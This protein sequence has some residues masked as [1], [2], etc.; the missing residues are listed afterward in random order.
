MPNPTLKPF[1]EIIQTIDW[2]RVTAEI[3]AIE[4]GQPAMPDYER[5]DVRKLVLNAA[6]RWLPQDLEEWQL[7]AVEE[8][9]VHPSLRGILDLRGRHK[10]KYKVFEPFAGKKFICDWKT[11]RGKLDADWAERYQYS[12]QW[13][14]YTIPHPDTAVFSYR[15]ISRDGST[16]EILVEVPPTSPQEALHYLEQLQVMRKALGDSL[17]WPRKMPGSCRAY[18]RDCEFLDHCQNNRTH[19]GLIDI[20][21]PLSYS[22]AE[23]FLLCP[24]KHRLMQLAAGNADDDETLAFGKA[25]HRGIAEVYTQAFKL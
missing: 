17:P 11:T 12:W 22:S 8:R 1:S 23:T 15:G 6:E 21:K 13:K 2:D 18:G 10:G 16:R 3:N 14:L 7:D 9:F 20:S 4:E 5:Q 24:E 25:F 19:T